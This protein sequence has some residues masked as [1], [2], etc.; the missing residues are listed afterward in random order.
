MA[1]KNV[2]QSEGVKPEDEKKP[3]EENNPEG[4]QGNDPAP[5]GQDD[6]AGAAGDDQPEAFTPAPARQIKITQVCTVA[7]K[8]VRP[9]SYDVGTNGLTEKICEHLV[10]QKVAE[11]TEDQPEATE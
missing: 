2:K 11:W 5:T 4:D 10:G 7:G 3:D 6:D 1:R 8:S 9:G